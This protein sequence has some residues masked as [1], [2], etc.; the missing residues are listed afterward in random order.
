V[1]YAL[2]LNV[3]T[4]NNTGIT[5]STAFSSVE[6]S[7]SITGWN[8]TS[9]T[10]TLDVVFTLIGL[11]IINNI[12]YLGTDNQGLQAFQLQSSALASTIRFLP[13]GIADGSIVPVGI[14]FTGT[15][16][17]TLHFP[18]FSTSMMYDPNFSVT[19]LNQGGDGADLKLLALLSLL[20]I[21]VA[22][23]LIAMAAGMGL[24]LWRRRRAI[25]TQNSINYS[26]NEE[27]HSDDL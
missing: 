4:L 11:P 14:T 6:M 21:P 9:P 3:Q 24:C 1:S 8:F 13:S 12:F 27:I 18:H 7:I 2:Y 20:I 5:F 26:G 17:L 22:F 25:N 10:N 16:G 19:F 15:S 23:I